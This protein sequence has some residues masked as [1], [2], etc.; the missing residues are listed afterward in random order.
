MLRER[1]QQKSACRGRRTTAKKIRQADRT[2]NV[3]CEGVD[4]EDAKLFQE[5]VVTCLINNRGIRIVYRIFKQPG[6]SKVPTVPGLLPRCEDGIEVLILIAT[7]V[8]PYRLSIARMCRVERDGR[9]KQAGR[10]RAARGFEDR[11][12]D[13]LGDEIAA[14][15][16]S[17][18]D[19]AR[20]FRNL[21]RELSC[22]LMKAELFV[23][24]ASDEAVTGTNNEME[25]RAIVK[26]C[27]VR[28]S[29]RC[30]ATL[31]P[32]IVFLGAGG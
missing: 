19:H 30:P 4:L 17:V 11:L 1:K 3:L 2:E 26:C 21:C 20:E 28:I 18:D 10:E 27:V 22:L 14:E 25:Q 8:Y 6:S 31:R 24:V 15:S 5:R 7:L 12:G 13:L 29:R 9:D 23:V 16:E 32:R